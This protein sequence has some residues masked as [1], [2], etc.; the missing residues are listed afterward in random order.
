MTQSVP[1]TSQQ[2]DLDWSQVRETVMMLNLA[3]ARIEKAMRDG[4]ESIETLSDSFTTI[5]SNV[6]SI[7]QANASLDSSGVKETIEQNCAHVTDN[8]HDAIVAFQFY[9]KLTQRLHHVS[10]SLSALTELV[11]DP[12]RLYNPFEWQGLQE[13]ILSRYTLDSDR[14]M[15]DAILDGKAL[16][17][18]LDMASQHPESKDH[19]ELF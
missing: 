8:V 13:K 11:D 18:V 7:E 17:D 15:F 19:I 4:D 12:A 1:S 3:V 10:K 9:D 6:R 2:P 16:K 5:A 14:A